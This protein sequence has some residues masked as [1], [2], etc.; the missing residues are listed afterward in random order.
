MTTILLTIVTHCLIAATA[1]ILT[2]E[3]LTTIG[4]VFAGRIGRSLDQ[5]FNVQTGSFKFLQHPTDCESTQHCMGSSKLSPVGVALV[6]FSFEENQRNIVDRTT[7]CAHSFLCGGA[8]DHLSA[9]FRLKPE[10]AVVLVGT[11]PPH[12]SEYSFNVLLYSRHVDST[13]TATTT[14]LQKCPLV[15]GTKQQRC[16]L[17]APISTLSSTRSQEFGRQH[18]QVE[19][20]KW[21]NTFNQ[22]VAIIISGSHNT[23]RRMQDGLVDAGMPEKSINFLPIPSKKA[24]SSA[25]SAS[26]LHLTL[27]DQVGDLFTINLKMN[28]PHQYADVRDYIGTIPFQLFR[29]SPVPTDSLPQQQSELEAEGEAATH[30]DAQ[31]LYEWSDLANSDQVNKDERMAAAMGG[32]Y[33]TFRD[34]HTRPV[35]LNV[36]L[37]VLENEIVRH[38][39]V[40]EMVTHLGTPLSK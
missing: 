11:T 28:E 5:P 25:S 7:S 10:E 34:Q 39:D 1:E 15:E 32:R 12:H 20:Q 2:P 9:A 27:D 35:D 38:L 19:K 16:V 31:V 14:P 30:P 4:S 23:T 40:K 26:D 37:N 13:T 3:Q 6:P 24:A 29:F 18:I 36:M 21:R 22:P 17:L 33:E 8:A